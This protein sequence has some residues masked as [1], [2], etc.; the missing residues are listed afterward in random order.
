MINE[1]CGNQPSVAQ[2]ENFIAMDWTLETPEARTEKVK[3]IVANTP[4]ERL[5]PKYLEKLSNYILDALTKEE[6]KQKFIL[7]D[8]QM[9]TVNKRETS[10]EGLVGK[11]ENGEDGIYNMITNDKNILF[12]P[13][14]PITKK[15][16]EDIPDLQKLFDA[17]KDVEEQ[18]KTATG[19]RRYKLKQ[20]LKE[21]YQD[22][23]EIKKAFKKPIYCVNLVRGASKIDLSEH[24]D[25]IDGSKVI[26]DGLINFYD[27]RHVCAILCNYSKLKEDSW[28][29]VSSDIKWLMEDFDA[30]VERTLK[31]KYPLYYDL[32]IYKID[33]KQN[34]EIQELLYEKHGTKHSVEYISSLWRNKIPKLIVEQATKEYLEWYYTNVEKGQWK[35]C[36]CCGQFKLANNLFFS[37]NK[38]SKDGWYSICKNCRSQKHKEKKK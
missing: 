21:M 24:I 15:D 1:T 37:K 14:A 10:F 13:K 5:T 31:E 12:Q 6:K 26:S 20:Q 36:S 9:V 29:K 8:N 28:E 38:T 23:Y 27:E 17:I 11:M 25:I 35:K 22:Q 32:V 7:T 4:S 18:C 16:L 3:E 30:L 19:M 33:G 34:I 2:D